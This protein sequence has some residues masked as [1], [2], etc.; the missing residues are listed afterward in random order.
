MLPLDEGNSN[1]LHFKTIS[2]IDFSME[3]NIRIEIV[4]RYI[5]C[6]IPNLF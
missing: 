6:K 2:M 1:L 3:A 5:N 4:K